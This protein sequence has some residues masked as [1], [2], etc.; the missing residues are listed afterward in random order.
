MHERW[1]PGI[2]RE[3][4]GSGDRAEALVL[5]ERAGQKR[6]LLAYAPLSLEF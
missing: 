2:I 3:V 5:F 1:G 6:L 4:T